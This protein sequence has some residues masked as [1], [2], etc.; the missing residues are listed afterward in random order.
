MTASA[1]VIPE[2]DNKGLRK[3]GLTTGA[4][5]VALFGLAIPLLR[6]VDLPRWPWMVAA[7]F[8]VPALVALPLMRLIYQAWMKV[9]L[10]LGAI[11]SRIILGVFFF[12]VV[13]PTGLIMR[14]LGK[15]PMARKLDKSASTYRVPSRP[16]DARSMEGPF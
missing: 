1:H 13:M 3:F 14:V 10:V 2:L 16:R 11:N 9:G 4:I 5:F 6:G 7:V 12:L 15:D 8:W